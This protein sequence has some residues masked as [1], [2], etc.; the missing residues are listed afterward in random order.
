MDA[1]WALVIAAVV[2]G[3]VQVANTLLTRGKLSRIEAKTDRVEDK[4]DRIE[5]RADAT[6]EQVR[7][8]NGRTL[9]QVAEDTVADVDEMR[10]DIME[11]AI[12]FARHTGDRHTHDTVM[13]MRQ[14]R[15]DREETAR[16]VR[17][18]AEGD[19]RAERRRRQRRDAGRSVDLWDDTEEGP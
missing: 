17:E 5:Q 19:E 15:R 1:G 18:L 8:S 11:L 2:T 9:A 7:T 3:A 14:D 6:H 13:R 10:G 4:A 12:Q 16:T